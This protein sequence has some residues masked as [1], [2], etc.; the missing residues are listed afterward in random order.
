ME[1]PQLITSGSRT[2]PFLWRRQGGIFGP[3]IRVRALG[4]KVS[5]LEF[6]VLDFAEA[7]Y[8]RTASPY[9]VESLELKV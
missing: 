5:G 3:G 8:N 6:G 9:L 7:D 2:W 1:M 4:F